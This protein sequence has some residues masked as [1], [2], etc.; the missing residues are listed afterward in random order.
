M[1]FFAGCKGKNDDNSK[2]SGGVKVDLG[3][4]GTSLKLPSNFPKDIVPLTKDAN[5]INVI[6]NKDAM[7]MG[8]TFTTGEKVE[9]A[10]DFYRDILKAGKD[11]SEVNSESGTVLYGFLGGYGVT[12]TIVEY[13]DKKVSIMLNVAYNEKDSNGD[14]AANS[15]ENTVTNQGDSAN[16]EFTQ[17][18]QNYF[19]GLE[20]V[21]LPDEYPKEKYPVFKGDKVYNSMATEDDNGFAIYLSVASK[22][23]MKEIVEYYEKAW[24][25]IANKSKQVSTT[26]FL[27]SGKIGKDDILLSGSNYPDKE[28]VEYL[29]TLYTSKSA[30]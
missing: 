20:A 27:L 6:D 12:V 17:E 15:G 16:S 1:S 5:I 13:D 30:E 19:E 10:A 11:Y 8:I 9:A 7:A 14:T 3:K 21:E 2:E 24:G 29:I 22:S 26:D 23:K 28:V 18:E 25:N 4:S